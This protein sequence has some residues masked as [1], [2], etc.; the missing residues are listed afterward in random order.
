M[1]TTKW[2]S[3]SIVKWTFTVGCLAIGSLAMA[4]QAYGHHPFRHHHGCFGSYG[5]GSNYYGG[6]SSFSGLSSS[7]YYPSLSIGY[8]PRYYSVNYYTPTYFAPVYYPPVY[9][10]PAFSPCSTWGSVNFNLGFPVA[11]NSVPSKLSVGSFASTN[12]VNSPLATQTRPFQTRTPLVSMQ[13]S[14]MDSFEQVTKVNGSVAN[15][16]SVKLVS[17]KPILLQPYSPIWTKAAVG[18]VD[19]M[20]AAGELD[21]AHS[22]CKSMERITQPKGSG[23]YLRQALLNYF[24][25]DANVTQS[26]STDEILQLL[27]LACAAGSQVQPSELAKDSL[28]DYFSACLV[29]VNGT[30]ERLSKSVLELPNNS[31]RELLLLSAL[32]KLDGQPERAK[33]FANEVEEQVANSGSFR[34]NSLLEACLN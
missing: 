8:M 6:Y 34:W 17:R 23:V 1:R 9:Y 27:D 12:Q 24:S 20:V 18:I 28:G 3:R 25:T 13:L 15:Q 30:L 10:T 32:L 2:F 21:H 26:S 29:D 5:W 22:S 33:L 11:T 7:Y 4:S 16:P 14:K 31:G 19:D